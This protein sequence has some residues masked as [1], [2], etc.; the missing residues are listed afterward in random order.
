MSSQQAMTGAFRSSG[1]GGA[2]MGGYDSDVEGAGAFQD[3]AATF[4]DKAVS[5]VLL[6]TSRSTRLCS[7]YFK[8]KLKSVKCCLLICLSVQLSVRKE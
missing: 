2:A 3:M 1:G 5:M 8:T 4:S 7:Q 6:L